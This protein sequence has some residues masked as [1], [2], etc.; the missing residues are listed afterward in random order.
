MRNKNKINTGSQKDPSESQMKNMKH[1]LEKLA[2]KRKFRRSK[3]A[4]LGDELD[5][6]RFKGCRDSSF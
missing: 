6:G 5:G 1:S 3:L 2:K 4:G